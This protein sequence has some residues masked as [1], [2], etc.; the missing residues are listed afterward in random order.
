MEKRQRTGAVQDA[1]AL[2]GIHSSRS[3]L[4]CA[5]PLA[6]CYGFF[7]VAR[8][9]TRSTNSCV[10]MPSC[11]PLG[12][13][14]SF[15][16]AREAMSAF[17]QLSDCRAALALALL[18][19]SNRQPAPPMVLSPF[20]TLSGSLADTTSTLRPAP[21]LRLDGERHKFENVRTISIFVRAISIFAG[22]LSIFAR[23]ISSIAR[24]ISNIGRTIPNIGRTISDS[25]PAE[26]LF[27]RSV[28]NIARPESVSARMKAEL[29]LLH[30]ALPIPRSITAPPAAA[31]RGRGDSSRRP[32]TAPPTPC[33]SRCPAPSSSWTPHSSSLPP[34]T[35]CRLFRAS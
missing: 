26:S 23:S 1:G 34:G 10:V 9:S 24:T 14:D 12:M 25:G 35:P 32:R 13:M 27:A 3:V 15:D 22:T 17:F 11:R 31:A 19:A 2:T 33:S 7:N 28:S 6:L 18:K 5:S 20:G 8:Y 4:E 21:S 16:C 30:S 29:S